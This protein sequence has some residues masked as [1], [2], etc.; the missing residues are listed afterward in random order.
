MQV[1]KESG[2]ELGDI[3]RLIVLGHFLAPWHGTEACSHLQQR[4]LVSCRGCSPIQMCPNLHPRPAEQYHR[5]LPTGHLRGRLW[6]DAH[7]Y[8]CSTTSASSISFH[9]LVHD[10]PESGYC[11]VGSAINEVD[12]AVEVA[13]HANRFGFADGDTV[14]CAAG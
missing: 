13:P 6:V 14:E 7:V 2:G 9:R 1:F 3:F 8:S 12:G 10:V 5:T 11:S 4:I